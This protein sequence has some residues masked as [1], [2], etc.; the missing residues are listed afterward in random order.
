MSL[1]EEDNLENREPAHSVTREIHLDRGILKIGADSYFAA[2]L[3]VL[4]VDDV[5]LRQLEL[6]LVPHGHGWVVPAVAHLGH[7]V[8]D[9]K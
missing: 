8:G 6:P 5:E 4:G 9:Y 1:Q 3:S 7:G 2:H